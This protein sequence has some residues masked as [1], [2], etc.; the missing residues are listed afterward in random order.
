MLGASRRL[1]M[2]LRQAGVRTVHA[3]VRFS[4]GSLIVLTFRAKATALEDNLA[5]DGSLAVYAE[6]VLKVSQ[7]YLAS[8]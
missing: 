8:G 1:H 6:V 4:I 7:D 3:S 2:A 5:V